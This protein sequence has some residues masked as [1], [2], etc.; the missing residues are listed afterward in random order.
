M[1]SETVKKTIKRY[2]LLKKNDTVLIGVSGGPDSLTLLYVLNSLKKEFKLKLHIAHL[3][4]MLRRDSAGDRKFVEIVAQK[5]DIPVTCEKINIKEI[6]KIGSLE[7]ICRDARLGFFFKIAKNIKADKIALGHNL[8][9]QAETVLMRLLRGSGLYGLSGILPKR[10]IY[11]F[12]IIRPLIEV[13]RKEITN[14]LKR[15]K[16]IPRVDQSN[17]QSIYLRNKIRNKLLPVLEK[18]YNRNIKQILSNTAES[19][20]NDY[21]FLNQASIEAA[22]RLGFKINLNRFACL[23]TAV[24]RM[25][26]RARISRLKGDTRRITFKHIQEIEDLI[27]NRPLNSLVD[28]PGNI[29]IK[30]TKQSLVFSRQIPRR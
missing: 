30:K 9:D 10:K 18:Y 4:H 23:H 15:K 25:V 1:V 11:G 13:K 29:R 16:I 26:L 24:Q 7:E 17:Y 27:S 5:L 12:T 14:F 6:A 22:K 8:D 20:A 21:D 3:D 2:G 28:L 19:I